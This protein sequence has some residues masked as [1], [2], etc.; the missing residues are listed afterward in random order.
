MLITLLSERDH[1]YQFINEL[2][3]W[4]SKIIGRVFVPTLIT[5]ELILFACLQ[6]C[7]EHHTDLWN[8][9]CSNFAN[10]RHISNVNFFKNVKLFF[11]N[12]FQIII[13]RLSH[14]I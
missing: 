1:E 14:H 9:T 2:T 3:Q 13:T 7:L 10:I 5:V 4:Q 11:I 6:K 8:T 12:T